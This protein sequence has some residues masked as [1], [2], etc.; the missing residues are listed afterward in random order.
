MSHGLVVFGC[1][2]ETARKAK[3]SGVTPRLKA[4]SKPYQ[5]QSAA[6]DFIRLAGAQFVKMEIRKK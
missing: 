3:E 1:D 2:Q 5:T 6:E 4:L